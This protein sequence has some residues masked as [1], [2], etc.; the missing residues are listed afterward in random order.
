M[1][2][3]LLQNEEMRLKTGKSAVCT[4]GSVH[5]LY[6]IDEEVH[7]QGVQIEALHFM[8]E[9]QR[10][11]AMQEASF[12]AGMDRGARQERAEYE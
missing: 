3:L 12:H 7:A 1:R 5:V 8:Q 4:G 2:T 9:Q 11:L 6:D 10:L